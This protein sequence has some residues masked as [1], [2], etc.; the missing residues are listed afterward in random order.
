MMEKFIEAH[1]KAKAY[2]S[3]GQVKYFSVIA[4][5]DAVVGNS[6]SGLYEV[7]SFG[8]PTVNIG[9]RQKGRLQAASIINCQPQASAIKKAITYA[10]A[11]D[12]SNVQN[13]YGDGTSSIQ[14]LS[15]LKSIPDYKALL[16]KQFFMME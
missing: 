9:D 15:V 12:C 7:P 13:P 16:K 5:V 6:S 4:Q 2:T 10:F 3:L 11:M 8:K 1:P 14:M